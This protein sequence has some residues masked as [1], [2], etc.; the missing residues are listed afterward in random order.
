MIKSSF[1]ASCHKVKS[2]KVSK[3]REMYKQ[4]CGYD[5]EVYFKGLG[6]IELYQCSET[7]MLFWRPSS[8]AGDENFYQ[9]LSNKFDDYYKTERWEY[10]FAIKAIGGSTGKLLEIGCGKGF[11]L[12]RLESY[13]VKAEGL[14]LNRQAIANKVT[15]WPI[16]PQ[17][18]DTFGPKNR[19]SF[20]VVCSYQV[21]EHV[22][23]PKD[24]L[25]K[26]LNLLRPGG[27]LILSTPNNDYHIHKNGLDAFDLPPHHMNHF[28][29]GVYERIAKY[30]GIKL[31]SVYKQQEKRSRVNIREV[32][33]HDTGFEKLLRQYLKPIADIFGEYYRPGHTIMVVYQK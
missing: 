13:D 20:E 22:I 21:L 3:I 33:P 19:G 27:L 11:F 31:A 6:S 7:G 5:P 14:E 16:H 15:S 8:I 23:D 25:E 18:L 4:K 30:F 1:G 10:E 2:L 26:S 12:R 32:Q 29:E 9:E 17:L 24:F 28:N